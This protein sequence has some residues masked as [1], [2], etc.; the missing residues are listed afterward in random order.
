MSN[1]KTRINDCSMLVYTVQGSSLN[2]PASI[3]LFSPSTPTRITVIAACNQ[4]PIDLDQAHTQALNHCAVYIGRIQ[5][6]GNGA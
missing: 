5:S 6:T 3:C 1:G 2:N 4:L